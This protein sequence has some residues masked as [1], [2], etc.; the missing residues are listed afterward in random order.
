[1]DFWK[2]LYSG[3]LRPFRRSFRVRLMLLLIPLGVLPVFAVTQLAAYNTRSSVED[4]VIQSNLST[5]KWAGGYLDEQLSE[6]NTLTYTLFISP[7]LNRYLKALEDGQTGSLYPLQK[8]VTDTML[9]VYYTANTQLRD[10]ELYLLQGGKLFTI[11]T[12]E[13]TSRVMPEMPDEYRKMENGNLDVL[14]RSSPDNP[15]SFELVRALR[16][17]ENREN[18][19]YMT[20]RIN[21]RFTDRVT[22]LL[23]PDS[24]GELLIT[25]ASGNMLYSPTGTIAGG[26]ADTVRS[27]TGS[28]YAQTPDAYVFY[29]TLDAWGLRIVKVVPRTAVDL[30]AER[31]IRYGSIVG[32]IAALLAVMASAF[33]AWKTTAPIIKLARSI[34][35]ISFIKEGTPLTGRT[36][37][38]G[39]LELRMHKMSKRIREHIHTEYALNLEKKTAQL[40]ALQAQIN[41]HFLQNTLQL[42]GGM[43]FTETPERLYAVI[44]AV[45]EMFRYVVRGPAGLVEV[46]EELRHLQNYLFIQEHRYPGRIETTLDIGAGTEE[47]LVPKLILQPIAENAFQHA[48]GPEQALW[49]LDVAVRRLGEDLEIAITDHGKGM[50]DERLKELRSD[51]DQGAGRISGS[52]EHIGLANV[53]ARL[54]LR[55]GERYG[56]QLSGGEGIGTTIILRMPVSG[57]EENEG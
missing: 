38:I 28:G 53:E 9:S 8:D 36:D 7:S 35:N 15:D 39:L 33:A 2:A 26:A 16:R 46:K 1:M 21:W 14:I 45:S 48:F 18:L 57:G 37:E 6:F 52:G 41:P 11:S 23:N 31:T 20:L 3:L 56:L 50:S 19:G 4:E 10:I 44:R 42:I 43:A 12:M 34:Q 55:F 5:V 49:R 22:E 40:A 32:V 13:V 27:S 25:D 29:D 17:F 24:G 30:S 47:L 51:I 54:R